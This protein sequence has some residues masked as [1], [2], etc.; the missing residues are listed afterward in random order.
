MEPDF[1]DRCIADASRMRKTNT[2]EAGALQRCVQDLG[3]AVRMPRV[4][5][6]GNDRAR[7]QGGV[8]ATT[9]MTIRLPWLRRLLRLTGLSPHWQPRTRPTTASIYS[10]VSAASLPVVDGRISIMTG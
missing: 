9:G 3:P 1:Q 10:P 2:T 4:S 8:G 6:P 5:R 7:R